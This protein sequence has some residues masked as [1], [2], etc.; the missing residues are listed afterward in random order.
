MKK[1]DR[2]QDLVD[3]WEKGQPVEVQRVGPSSSVLSMRLSSALFQELSLRAESAGLSASQ[4]AREV[5]ERGLAT[6]TPTTPADV[7]SMFHRW[8]AEL[9]QGIRVSP[10]VSTGL[11]RSTWVTIYMPSG[12]L[13]QMSD[14]DGARNAGDTAGPK[15]QSAGKRLVA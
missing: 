15:T 10:R 6:E 2:D 14:Y 7:A 8:A 1:K 11:T 12:V 9:T 5:I 4:F 13:A 3:S